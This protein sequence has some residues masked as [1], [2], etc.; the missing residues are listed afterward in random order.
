MF[1]IL[2]LALLAVTANAQ[3]SSLIYLGV[4]AG[5]YT[6]QCNTY[7]YF[8]VVMTDPC[9]DLIVSVSKSSGEPNI[10]VSK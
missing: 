7:S 10:Y 9:L 5:P 3:T 4:P 8:N 1:V 2:W 6:N